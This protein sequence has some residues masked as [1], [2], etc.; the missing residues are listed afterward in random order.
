MTDQNNDAYH[1]VKITRRQGAKKGRVAVEIELTAKDWA[2]MEELE[3]RRMVPLVD[4]LHS[5]FIQGMEREGWK[6]P[7]LVTTPH[8]PPPRTYSLRNNAPE[9]S[10]DNVVKFR[11]KREIEIDEIMDDEIPF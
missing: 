7:D 1:S 6:N 2:W 8:S 9:H 4:M 3:D 5:G 10:E 11:P